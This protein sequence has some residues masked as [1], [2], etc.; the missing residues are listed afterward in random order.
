MI[1]D[2]TKKSKKALLGILIFISMIL[3][4]EFVEYINNTILII[5][6]IFGGIYGLKIIF[7]YYYCVMNNNNK[8]KRK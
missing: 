5:Y 1:E 7:P 6:V 3:T 8:F 4:P 2:C